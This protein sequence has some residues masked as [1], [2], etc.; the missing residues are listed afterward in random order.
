MP[1]PRPKPRSSACFNILARLRYTIG[2]MIPS[3]ATIAA[4]ATARGEAGVA[5][6]RISGREAWDIAWE[7]FSR[8][9]IVFQPGRFYH[10]W[11]TDEGEI[12]DEVIMLMFK[13]PHSYTGE[14]VAEIHCHGGDYISHKILSLCTRQGARLALPGEFTKRA[15]LNGKMDLTQAESV[16]DLV[17]ARS[18]RML[19]Q[20]SANLRNRSLGKYI[21]EISTELMALQAQIV[22][23]IDFPD[24]VEEPNRALLTGRLLDTLQ[25][26]S[27]LKES[28]Q[29]NRMVREGVKVALLGMP[30]SGKS[31]LFNAL[32]SADRSIVTEEP[33]TTRDVVTESINL[34]GVTLTLIDTAGI[35]ETKHSIEMMGIE[36]SWQA[37]SEAQVVLYLIDA[38]VG[39][40]RYDAQVLS[41]LDADNT[42]VI[43]NKK[44]LVPASNTRPDWIY[45][46]ARTGEGLD[47]LIEAIRGKI[48]SLTPEE[49]GMSVALNQ[50]QIAC[51]DGI[52]ECLAQG[53][54][55]L[56]NPALPLDLVTVPLTDALR[57]VDELM[58]RD[59]G[60]EVL[61]SVFAQ[62]CVGK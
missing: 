14:D 50:R 53:G 55:V 23:H 34:D 59:T 26:V 61:S 10:G 28:A 33:G 43:G 58:G 16:M 24:E 5:I 21:D 44:D 56:E 39:M 8:K 18:D 7:L 1:R 54:E 51:C 11:I 4:I 25:K 36:R 9:N 48:R 38:S 15:F 30:N 37:A 32:L 2:T 52:E 42:I 27:R 12:I 13:A 3:D 45:I 46:S 49:T 40:L 41:R 35:R 22:A 29:R 17:S 47:T 57:Q 19:N 20:A 60:E 62:F 6:I 31:S